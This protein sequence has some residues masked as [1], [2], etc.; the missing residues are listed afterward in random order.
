MSESFTTM[1]KVIENLE[2]LYASV[3][4]EA[5]YTK[6][7][8]HESITLL[9]LEREKR[10]I[11]FWVPFVITMVE[12]LGVVIITAA[13]IF[14]SQR[15]QGADT[16]TKSVGYAKNTFK[17]ITG[18]DYKAKFHWDGVEFNIVNPIDFTPK[19]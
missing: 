1:S 19:M 4:E 11:P 8:M 16:L 9:I 5:A 2:E 15:L 12:Y 17:L 6:R 18:R 10:L 7:V 3:P 13:Y 14:R